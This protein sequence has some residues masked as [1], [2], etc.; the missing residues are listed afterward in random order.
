M[1][2]LGTGLCSV[3]EDALGSVHFFLYMLYYNNMFQKKEKKGQ[4]S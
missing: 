3:C 1:E 2:G 4:A